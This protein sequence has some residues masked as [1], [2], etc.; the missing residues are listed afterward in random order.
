VSISLLS[1]LGMADVQ[2]VQVPRYLSELSLQKPPT[3]VFNVDDL[4]WTP[5][6]YKYMSAA[7]VIPAERI[8][9]F[10]EGESRRGRTRV[11]YQES[12]GG[13]NAKLLTDKRATCIYGHER[14]KE[15]QL[16][17][18][19]DVSATKSSQR[20]SAVAMH[21][22][23]KKGC[24][25]TFFV[26]E[27]AGNRGCLYITFPFDEDLG[28]WKCEHVDGDGNNPHQ[29]CLEHVQHTQL[30]KQK[31]ISMLNMRAGMAL[32]KSGARMLSPCACC[33]CP[34][35]TSIYAVPEV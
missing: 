20:R 23:I 32:I 11:L 34:L 26:K 1:C 21:E 8:D 24:N 15:A 5:V 29:D 6:K 31:V 3:G 9:D 7:A 33:K 17:S 16:K 25:Y 2:Q 19:G 14:R 4:E 35:L 13:A 28:K 10:I 22:S 27:Y 30:V 12:H 18:A